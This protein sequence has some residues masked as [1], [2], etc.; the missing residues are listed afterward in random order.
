MSWLGGSPRERDTP[1]VGLVAVS[2]GTGRDRI[3][4][5]MLYL[6]LNVRGER[7]LLLVMSLLCHGP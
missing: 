1:L 6:D 2:D 3:S 7:D 4:D 5:L